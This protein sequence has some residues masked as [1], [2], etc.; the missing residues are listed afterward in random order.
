[1][2]SE[3]Y[4]CIRVGIPQETSTFSMPRLVSP[5]DSSMVL[6]CSCVWMRL[7]SSKFSSSSSFN[8]KRSLDLAKGVVLLQSGNA[9]LQLG[10]GFVNILVEK[11]Y[12]RKIGNSQSNNFYPI[13]A[14][15]VNAC[16]IT[17]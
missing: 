5:R 9:S 6:P 1:M 12:L 15:N 17:F 16:Q 13:V 10:G 2:S 8:L 4:P 7:T 3:K 14:F 11:K